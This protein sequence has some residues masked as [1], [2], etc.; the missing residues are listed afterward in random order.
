MLSGR[1]STH[2]APMFYVQCKEGDVCVGGVEVCFFTSILS[3]MRRFAIPREQVFMFFSNVDVGSMK[4]VGKTRFGKC[5]VL[6]LDH[7]REWDV[8]T[9]ARHVM[10]D[11]EYK[12]HILSSLNFHLRE[13]ML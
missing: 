6:T 4:L 2:L 12:R 9:G 11:N 8:S 10:L 3:V 1:F 13:P 5:F 7:K